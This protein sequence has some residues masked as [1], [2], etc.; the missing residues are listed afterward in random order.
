[1][2]TTLLHDDHTKL[3]SDIDR[4]AEHHQAGVEHAAA[5]ARTTFLRERADHMLTA[6]RELRV[7]CNLLH[8][9]GEADNNYRKT[10]ADLRSLVPDAL[11]S[12][13]QALTAATLDLLLLV[14]YTCASV[15]LV[16]ERRNQAIE[17]LAGLQQKGQP[18][19]SEVTAQ[20]KAVIAEAAT[21]EATTEQTVGVLEQ[22]LGQPLVH[23]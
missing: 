2:R 15:A 22:Q 4:L 12:P 5:I 21:T 19:N 7:A 8:F 6:L 13:S 9:I 20:I 3:F 14:E 10:R 17:R 11:R 18:V 23:V 1:M 16:E